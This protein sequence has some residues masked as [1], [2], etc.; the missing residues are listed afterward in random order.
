M[1]ITLLLALTLATPPQPE[2]PIAFTPEAVVW[3]DGPPSLPP[4]SKSAILEGNPRTEGMFTMRIRV[5]AGAALAPHWHPRHERVTIL[6]GAVELGFGSVANTAAV[7]RYGAGSFYVNP[8]RMMHYVYFPEATELQITGH[9][10][11]EIHTTDV[12]PPQGEKSTATVVIRNITPHAGAELTAAT[13]LVANVD[14]NISNFRPETFFLSMKFE[15]AVPGQTFSSPGVVISRDG[16]PPMP[17]RPKMLTSAIG[18][19]MVKQEMEPIFRNPQLKRPIRVRI[20]V[21]E[22]TNDSSSIV[23]G[24]SDWIEYR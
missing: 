14:Y 2:A 5:P 22:Q 12:A 8:P 11:W 6:S 1:F 17:P 9:G 13:E 16:Q 15:S 19:A 4:G 23:A 24:M 18:T 21:H 7:V 10:P 20:Y 3:G